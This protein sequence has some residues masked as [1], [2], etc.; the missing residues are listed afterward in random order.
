M[1]NFT[2]NTTIQAGGEK[3]SA[4]A[5]GDYSEV[6]RMTLS[7][8]FGTSTTGT[9]QE[10]IQTHSIT[11]AGYA[12]D[13]KYLLIKNIGKS[14]IE[15][16]FTI[17]AWTDAAPD[18]HTADAER[19]LRF[20]I[21]VGD[22]ML[23][24]NIR[25]VD[26]GT[27][28]TGAGAG[29][30]TAAGITPDTNLYEALNNTAV[31]DPQ[32]VDGSGMA[33]DATVTACIVDD[34]SYL[35]PGDLIQLETEIIRIDQISSATA[36]I[37]T[38]GMYGSQAATHADDTPIR[39]P[40]FNAYHKYG[41][42]SINGGGDGSAAK[43]KTDVNGRFK[44]FNF[45]GYGRDAKYEADGI[46][47]GSVSIQFRTEGGYQELGLSGITGS[48]HSG[49]AAS[50]NYAF[51]IQVD[52]GTNFNNLTFTTDTSNL[53]F[54]GTNGVISKIQAALNTQYYTAGNLFQRG[55]NV[56]IVNGDIRF[57]SRTNHSASAIALTAEDG[58]DASFFG[59]GRIP[60]VGAI[61]PA[62]PKRFANRY[63]NKSNVAPIIG[64]ESS[65]KSAIKGVAGMCTDD[66]KGNLIGAATGTINYGS[67]ALDFT[68]L[69]NADFLVWMSYGSALSGNIKT[70]TENCNAIKEF[71]F[72]GTNWNVDATIEFI[73]MN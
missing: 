62:V 57:T 33:S 31:G 4:T 15:L 69:P 19:F 16:H 34:T 53:N 30:M 42:T 48:T 50:T 55:V 64:T 6:F 24:P 2:A 47:P 65:I 63:T 59:T 26:Y 11:S 52:G 41:D 22:Y 7:S 44:C 46:T 35:Y 68:A 37:V 32:L 49:L 3:L 1:P 28:G 70:E 39:L 45:F 25:L 20:L 23:L 21:P 8:P 17:E 66:G 5:T 27:E 71:R 56:G 51:D 9:F 43:C 12:K 14:A 61:E 72:R 73:G 10:A 13:L 29:V 38:R 40:F 58:A 54:G 18:A 67:G 36:T 60:A